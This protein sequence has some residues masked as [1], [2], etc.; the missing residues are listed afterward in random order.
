MWVKT[1]M[2]VILSVARAW[3]WVFI[4]VMTALGLFPAMKTAF[5]YLPVKMAVKYDADKN[6]KSGLSEEI[7]TF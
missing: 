7:I 4:V 3:T 2:S 1:P 5:H 6:L